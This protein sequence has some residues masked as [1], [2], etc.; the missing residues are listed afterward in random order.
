V[1][2]GLLVKRT[3][4]TSKNKVVTGLHTWYCENMGLLGQII[5]HETSK[6]EGDH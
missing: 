3:G 4:K 6:G 2:G 1:N 5:E